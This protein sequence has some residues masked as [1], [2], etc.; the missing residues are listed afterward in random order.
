MKAREEQRKKNE[1]EKRQREE[2]E[3]MKRELDEARRDDLTVLVLNLSLKA[4]ERDIW[5]F[6]SEVRRQVL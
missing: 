3:K 6:F 4:T 5:K 1:Q 2:E